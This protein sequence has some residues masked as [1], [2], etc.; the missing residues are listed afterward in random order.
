MKMTRSALPLVFVLVLAACG[1]DDAS[2][3]RP[4]DTNAS[5]DVTLPPPDDGD[6][7]DA[8]SIDGPWRLVSGIVDGSDVAMVAGWDVTLTV[9]GTQLWGTA[10]CNGYG[11]TVDAAGGGFAV[12]ELGWTEMGCEPAVMELEQSFLLSLPGIDAHAVVDDMLTI[13]GPDAEW[14]FEREAPVPD[15]DI[16]GTTWVLDTHLDGDAATNTPMMELATL[17]L[18]EDGTFTGST[19]C[20]PL[21]GEWIA[22]GATLQ[23]PSFT[24]ID[25]PTAGVCAPESERLDG[26][27]ISVLESGVTVEVD[28]SRMTLMAPG[29][30][31]LSYM[32]G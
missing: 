18:H 20:R 23:F 12:D 32:A 13:T 24:A 27:I 14:V 8:A 30:E 21:V 19:S 10:A 3:N 28:A 15:A 17:T 7:G 1:G 16:V 11:G 6:D 22:T 9:D 2:S 5:S 25:D 29:D 4:D 26:L 31:G